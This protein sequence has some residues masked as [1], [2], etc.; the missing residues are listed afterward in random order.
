MY[1]LEYGVEATITFALIDYSATDFESTPVTFVTGD[2]KI[3]KDG[4]AL[5]NSTNAPSHI[6]NGIYK[7]TITA[8]ELQ[9]KNIGIVIIDQSGT[10]EWED[11]FIVIGT[12]NHASAQL[13]TFDIDNNT[14]TDTIL[15]RDVDQV[16]ATA[17]VH[18]L[19]GVILKQMGKVDIAGATLTIKE[20]DGTTTFATQTVTTDS[21]ADPVTGAGLAS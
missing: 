2:T 7:L 5:A 21:G 4:A 11:Q 1:T 10:K 15:K 18:S 20:T 6:G 9:A 8:T 19:A 3:T 17:P 12:V 14:V 13:P 16:E